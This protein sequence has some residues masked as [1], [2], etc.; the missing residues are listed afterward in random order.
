MWKESDEDLAQHDMVDYVVE[1]E[2]K[3]DFRMKLYPVLKSLCGVLHRHTI[4]K[5]QFT[6]FIHT[7]LGQLPVT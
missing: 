6:D 1:S 4:E 5:S 3:A 2:I 7:F